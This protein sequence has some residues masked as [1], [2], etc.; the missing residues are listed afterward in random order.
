MLI[1]LI[2][3]LSLDIVAGGVAGAAFAA[4]LTGARLPAA[5]WRV[6]PV[7][8]WVVYTM[9]HLLDGRR[10]GPNASN[11]R[12]VLHAR[13]GLWIALAMT[14]A[15]GMAAWQILALPRPVIAGGVALAAL[16]VL[17]LGAV[18]RGFPAWLPREA[19]VAF[20]YVAGIWMGPLV[21]AQRLGPAVWAAL[22]L[23]AALALGYLFAYAWFEAPM[24][25]ADGSPS[26]ALEWGRPRLARATS[27]LAAVTVAGALGAAVW[28]GPERTPSFLVLAVVGTVP[29]TML[30][31][32][33]RLERFDRYRH[34]EWALLLLLVPV[35]LAHAG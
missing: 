22:V 19:S 3:A 28:A 1:R 14:A 12:H 18:R 10:V 27:V 23:H 20:I 24:D 29:W 8:I 11:D 31:A 7:A 13:H 16:V 15:G 17:H 35:L 5:F 25:R 30:R 21:L 33:V 4:H 32:T 26:V 6:L 2:R 34:A 9:D